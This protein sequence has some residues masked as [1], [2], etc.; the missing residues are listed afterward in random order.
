MSALSILLPL[1]LLSVPL[2]A[3]FGSFGKNKVNFAEFSWQK[4]ETPHFNV[5]FFEEERE[6]TLMLLVDLNIITLYIR[7]LLIMV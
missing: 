7:K 3:Q 6:L 4:M 1:L 5:F 2:H